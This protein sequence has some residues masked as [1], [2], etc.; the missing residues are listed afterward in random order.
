MKSTIY[1]LLFLIVFGT[2]LKGQKPITITETNLQFK[3]GT[4]PGLVV[5]IPEVPVKTVTES[6]I[7]IQEKGTKSKVQNELGEMT[8]FGAIIKEIIGGSINIYSSVKE[9]DSLTI[10]SVAFEMKK[11]EYLT[12][13]Q[14]D[15]E[16][17]KA[18]QFLLQFAKDQYL[19][20]ADDQL[21]TE[22]K[23]LSKLESNLSSLQSEQSKLDKM[24]INN[25][26]S[27]TS[28]NSELVNLRA[29]LQSLNNELETQKGQYSTMEAGE[30]RDSKGKYIEDLKKQVKKAESDISAGEKKVKSMSSEIEQAQQTQLPTNIKEQEQIRSEVFIQTEVVRKYTN[31]YNTIKAY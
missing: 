23:K 17:G 3:H 15:Y 6:W 20:V 5:S 26:S 12:S 31:K 1:F 13:T 16:F 28:T 11:D 24:I 14:R 19:I 21:Q 22:K 10:L 2:S 29:K 9:G 7:K 8:I 30:G 18:K 25:N 27:I 4:I